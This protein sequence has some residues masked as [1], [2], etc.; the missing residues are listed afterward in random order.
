MIEDEQTESDEPRPGSR[1]V[2]RQQLL[3][4]IGGWSG[5][6]ITAIP[7]V[8]FVAVNAVAT[9]RW[10]IGA[11]V[12]SALLL[13]GYRLARRQSV[14]QA[15]TGLLGVVV[16]SIIAART[17]QAKGYFL[18]GIWSS[19]VYAAAFVATLVVRRPAIGL[20]WEFLDPTPEADDEEPVLW[21]RRRPLLFAYMLATAGA[22]LVF[23]TRGIVQ[24]ALFQHNATGWLAVARIAMGYPLYIAA[25]GFAFWVVRR[26]RNQL[27]VETANSAA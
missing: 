14:Q 18:L 1:E 23:L 25:I 9:L 13:A 24:L 10:A 5:T 27:A 19:F 26:A 8:V 20:L 7:T 21:H 6:V 12:G 17:G 15:M 11:A 16:A 3:N 4:S 22:A 2:Y